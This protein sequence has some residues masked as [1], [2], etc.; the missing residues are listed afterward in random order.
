M[1]FAQIMRPARLA[2]D[3]VKQDGGKKLK[4]KSGLG[5][6]EAECDFICGE[7]GELTLT[8]D[9]DTGTVFLLD[10]ARN[11]SGQAGGE[12]QARPAKQGLAKMLGY[13]G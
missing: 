12:D 2:L 6:V 5:R 8:I 4:A 1:C 13:L 10:L 11:S 7:V 9:N 3:A